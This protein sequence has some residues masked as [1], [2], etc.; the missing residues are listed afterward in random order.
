MSSIFKLDS[1]GNGPTCEITSNITT[2][3]AT[4]TTSSPTITNT[5]YSISS[6]NSSFTL[7]NQSLSPAGSCG[8][9]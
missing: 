8:C 3:S 2:S 4:V 5:T 7:T 1:N 6:Q 9:P